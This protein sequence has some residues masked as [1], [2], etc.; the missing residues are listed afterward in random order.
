[1]YD[2]L[3]NIDGGILTFNTHING[4]MQKNDTGFVSEVAEKKLY[5]LMQ[6]RYLLLWF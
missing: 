1:M 3:L 4:L 5:Q 2:F 6:R